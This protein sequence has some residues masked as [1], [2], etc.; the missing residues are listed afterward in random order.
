VRFIPTG[1]ITLENMLNYL[2]LPQVLAC[3]GSWLVSRDNLASSRFGAIQD[4]V[5][6]A[7]NRLASS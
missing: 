3:G 1:G 2:A 7:V 4:T 5:M 6:A